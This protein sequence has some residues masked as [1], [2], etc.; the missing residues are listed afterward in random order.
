MWIYNDL[1]THGKESTTGIQCFDD[2]AH[3]MWW[4]TIVVVI[5]KTTIIVMLSHYTS[6]DVGKTMP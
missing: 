6:I 3:D 5:V 1:Y 4:L 2:S